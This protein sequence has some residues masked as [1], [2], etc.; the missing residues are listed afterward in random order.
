M[1]VQQLHHQ[2]VSPFL[3]TNRFSDKT[4]GAVYAVS[5]QS[6]KEIANTLWVKDKHALLLFDLRKEFKSMQTSMNIMA[7][8]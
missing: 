7:T 1:N 4:L 6:A 8:A 2:P 3:V 5:I